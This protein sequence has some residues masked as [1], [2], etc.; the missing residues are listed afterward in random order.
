MSAY[1]HHVEEALARMQVAKVLADDGGVFGKP[2]AHDDHLSLIE[3]VPA[4]CPWVLQGFVD[5]SCE[6]VFGEDCIVDAHFVQHL[7]I[8][9]FDIVLTK[10][11]RHGQF[12]AHRF[13]KAAHHD[14][15]FGRIGHRDKQFAFRN[16]CLTQGRECR[17]IARN[18]HQI[19]LGVEHRKLG[20]ILIDDKD[21]HLFSGKVFRKMGS[22]GSCSD[23]DDTHLFL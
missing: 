8:A 11:P 3:F 12:C 23:Y 1:G 13:G 18:G 17:A 22:D 9:G 7:E 15:A 6:E 14:V 19:I 21:V 4:L 2:N 16:F 20:G 10:Y 5:A